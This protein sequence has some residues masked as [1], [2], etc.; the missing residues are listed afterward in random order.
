MSGSLIAVSK[1]ISKTWNT[2]VTPCL[3]IWVILSISINMK[4]T[5]KV[6]FVASL[7]VNLVLFLRLTAVKVPDFIFN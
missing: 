7:L 5:L 3:M 6:V 4:C 2:F 1:N